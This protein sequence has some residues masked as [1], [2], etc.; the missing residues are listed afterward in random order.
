MNGLNDV[1]ETNLHC[2]RC[3]SNLVRLVPHNLMFKSDLY[4]YNCKGS[5]FPKEWRK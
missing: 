3:N 2:D 1:E 5:A 4:C